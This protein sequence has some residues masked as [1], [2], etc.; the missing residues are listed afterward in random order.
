MWF[1]PILSLLRTPLNTARYN[2]LVLSALSV[3]LTAPISWSQSK[4][5][6]ADLSIDHRY[7]NTDAQS[8]I[9]LPMGSHK[10]TVEKDGSLRW[11]QWSLKR[12][13]LDVPIGFSSQMDGALAIEPFADGVDLNHPSSTPL[14]SQSQTLYRGRY[15]F[16]LSKLSGGGLE[17]EE[18]AYSV[19]PDQ[20]PA[21]LPTATSGSHGLD[22]VRIKVHNAS[23]E[24]LDFRLDLSGRS[25][26][27]PGHVDGETLVTRGGELIVEVDGI[28]YDP[29]MPAAEAIRQ[30]SFL[31]STTSAN[32]GLT[33]RHELPIPAGG[34]RILWLRLPYE[35]PASRKSELSHLSG[36]A[37]LAKAVAQ[38]DGIWARGA[39]VRYPQQALNDFFDSS[40]A[41][42]LILTEYD[43]KGDLWTL[44]GPDVYRQYWGR[45][46]Y[47]QARAM[48]V[49]G[50]LSP[51][52]ESI[53]H[54]FHIMNDDGEWDG[55]P[56]SGWPAWD[57]IGGNAGAVWDYYLYTRDKAW[58][59]QA[60]PYLLRSS[61][62]VRAHRE[63]TTLENVDGIPIGARPIRRMLTGAKC[64]AEPDPELKPG[65]KTYWYGLLP[66][67]YGDSGLPEG[68]SYSHNFLAAYGVR[69]SAEAARVL[70]K[71][72]DAAWLDKE[73]ESY[74]SAIRNSVE[75]SVRLEKTAL[76]YLPAQPTRPDAA[77]SQTFLAIW[78]TGLY[79]PNDPL[80]SGLLTRMES[81]ESQGLPTNV[82]WAGPAG[83]WPGES[84]NMS[85][86]YLLRDDVKKNAAMLIAALNHSY[87]TNVFK[88]EILTD[89]TKDRACDTPHSK[90]ENMEGTGDMP[91]AWGNANTVDLLR[92]MLVQERTQAP[93]TDAR[94][95]TLHLLAGLPAEWIAKMGE[96][97]SVERTPTTLG[98]M[99]SLKLTR[100]S[101]T[102]IH[103]EFDPGTRATDTFVHV[104][105][106]QGARLAE[107]TM[108]GHAMP[109]S[110]ITML[111]NGQQAIVAA[112]E[113]SGRVVF[114]F[115]F[116][117]GTP[118]GAAR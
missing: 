63:E 30:N 59:A 7:S 116:A 38:W 92:D 27:L 100:T 102:A 85:E 53:E 50:Y 42:V 34:S 77:Y 88:E 72:D 114:D 97:A 24:P 11:S 16:I 110:A 61:E 94:K 80:V 115:T 98:T 43:A 117:A 118:V 28:S 23:S 20:D 52:R 62:W 75:R 32:G 4:S 31:S 57:N 44:D 90:R 65:E 93:V 78:P 1:V 2:A 67:S 6:S 41:Y 12:K 33:L 91:E 107:A 113:L 106:P 81:E 89:V 18:L 108:N 8:L 66:W 56:T 25:R 96:T 3:L 9:G 60:Y 39:R 109:P 95:T 47:F 35:F 37:L 21:Q 26:N 105:L 83:I 99:V 73:Y 87:T 74:T 71:T 84:M 5:S 13:P 55:P 10:T 79:S 51:A 40:I 76:P 112:G 49:A 101:P 22:V 111:A 19:D 14:K 64:R 45:G 70:G 82:A 54:A 36:E 29:P 104:P 15:P 86:T 69:V 17:V 58:L 68:H 103:L 46:E 48:E